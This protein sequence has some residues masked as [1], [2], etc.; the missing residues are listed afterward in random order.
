MDIVNRLPYDLSE[1]ILREYA[2][3]HLNPRI[4]AVDTTAWMWSCSKDRLRICT[5]R[6]SIQ[7]GHCEDYDSWA[8]T[9]M[10]MACPTCDYAR[11]TCSTCEA[12]YR[13][14]VRE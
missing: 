6:G 13:D 8:K 7:L 2:H 10:R 14:A 5:E 12:R 11:K 4:R 9:Y 3:L 1:H